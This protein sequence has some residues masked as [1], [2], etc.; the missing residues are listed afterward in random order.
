MMNEFVRRANLGPGAE[1]RELRRG[2]AEGLLGAVGERGEKNAS[3]GFVFRPWR[4]SFSCIE[5]IYQ[6]GG[7]VSGRRGCG[8]CFGDELVESALYIEASA[9]QFGGENSV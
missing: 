8:F 1:V 9:N 5:A 3:A 6:G 2:I 7:L 4:A